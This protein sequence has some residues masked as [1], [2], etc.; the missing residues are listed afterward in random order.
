MSPVFQLNTSADFWL[1][2][3]VPDCSEYFSN[4][5]SLRYALH[6]AISLF[7]MSDWVFH[8]HE[9]AVKA[10][11]TFRNRKGVVVPVSDPASF[12]TALEQQFPDFGLIRGIAHAAKHLKL[13][14]VRPIPNAP[15]HAANTAVHAPT[16]DPNVFARGVFDT[17]RKVMLAGANGKDVEFEKILRTVYAMWTSLNSTYGW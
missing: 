12:A 2:M 1:E 13:N 9:A 4:K 15:S 5:E 8:T 6:A 14:D 7:H 17:G 10:N 11:F 3:A 16:F